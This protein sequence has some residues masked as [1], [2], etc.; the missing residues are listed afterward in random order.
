MARDLPLAELGAAIVREVIAALRGT[1]AAVS[2]VDPR[3]FIADHLCATL[4]GFVVRGDSALLLSVGDGSVRVD[5]EVTSLDAASPP[6]YLA[7]ALLG[8]TPRVE[9]RVVRVER[10]VGVATDG[11]SLSGLRALSPQAPSLTRHLVLMERRGELF[12]DGG[13]AMAVRKPKEASS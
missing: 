10:A 7:Y 4:L 3:R 2:P 5:E 1:L 8:R 11:V 9:A 13:V 12:D 6:S